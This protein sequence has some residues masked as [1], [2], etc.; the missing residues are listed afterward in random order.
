MAKRILLL[1]KH[2]QVGWELQRSLAPLGELW[3][4]GRDAASNPHWQGQPLHG[5]LADPDALARTVQLLQPDVIVNAAAYTAV[6]KAENEADMANAINAAGPGAVADAAR[7]L[8]VPLIHLSTDYV[9][10]GSLDRPYVEEDPTG[11]TGIYGASKLAGE[12]AQAIP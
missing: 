5:D 8:Q 2:G 9:F 3:A 11:P 12:E 1:G 10:D 7:E 4:L 6:D